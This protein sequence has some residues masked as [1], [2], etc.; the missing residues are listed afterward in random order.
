MGNVNI[1]QLCMDLL[2][3]NEVLYHLCVFALKFA[4]VCVLVLYSPSD[5]FGA[6][7]GTS[8]DRGKCVFQAERTGQEEQSRRRSPHSYKT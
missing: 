8:R 6:G 2:R 7:T 1:C 4:Y 3:C 5:Y